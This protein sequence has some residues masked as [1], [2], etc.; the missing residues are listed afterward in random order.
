[1]QCECEISIMEKHA[2]KIEKNDSEC[3]ESADDRCGLKHSRIPNEEMNE[4]WIK[5]IVEMKLNGTMIVHS[6][7]VGV[8]IDVDFNHGQ[9]F[10][11]LTTER[12]E[13]KIAVA[14]SD[15]AVK[16]GEMGGC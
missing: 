8:T 2:K 11:E 16:N 7:I 13:E 4:E 10:N 3:Y 9:P 6:K 15:A 1:M 14:A 5:V 12:I